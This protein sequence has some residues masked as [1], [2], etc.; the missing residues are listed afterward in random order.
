MTV[1]LLVRWRRTDLP[2]WRY[3]A[4][5]FLMILHIIRASEIHGLILIPDLFGQEIILWWVRGPIAVDAGIVPLISFL[6]SHG[7]GSRTQDTET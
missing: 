5:S 4:N 7:G 1:L 2:L 6:M 3:R